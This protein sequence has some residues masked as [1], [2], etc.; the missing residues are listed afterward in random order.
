MKIFPVLSGASAIRYRLELFPKPKPTS[1]QMVS[2]ITITHDVVVGRPNLFFHVTLLLLGFIFYSLMNLLCLF[3]RVFHRINRHFKIGWA[4]WG[5]AFATHFFIA[6]NS[7]FSILFRRNFARLGPIRMSK[8]A[9]W[10]A[11][12]RLFVKTKKYSQ[13]IRLK[14]SKRAICCRQ[15]ISSIHQKIHRIQALLFGL[16]VNAKIEKL[17]NKRDYINVVVPFTVLTEHRKAAVWQYPLAVYQHN[18]HSTPFLTL[19]SQELFIH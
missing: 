19:A 4:P 16:H 18:F 15:Q 8:K 11:N 14:Q 6:E 17:E 12:F 9:Q 3:L 1:C 5:W 13:I 7:I 10:C 2:I